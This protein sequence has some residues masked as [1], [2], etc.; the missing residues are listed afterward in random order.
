M[1]LV[2]SRTLF[3]KMFFR[4][5]Q[6]PSRL[7]RQ[8][9]GSAARTGSR[10]LCPCRSVPVSPVL[11]SFLAGGGGGGGYA[12]VMI[13]CRTEP[14]WLTP[15][16]PSLHSAPPTPLDCCPSLP[17][18]HLHLWTAVHHCTQPHLHLWTAVHHCTQPQLHPITHLH[19]L[20]SPW[21]LVYVLHTFS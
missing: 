4:R 17:L 18:T 21:Q 13:Q 1:F 8:T 3:R 14:T 2:C 12:D 16:R 7:C 15:G 10:S 19:L 20:T 11:P 9:S 6:A 5:R